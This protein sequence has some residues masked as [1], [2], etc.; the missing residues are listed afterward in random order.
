MTD[1]N[2]L[3]TAREAAETQKQL[4][5]DLELL[6]LRTKAGKKLH[7]RGHDMRRTFITLARTDGAID[8]LLRWVTHG[9]TSDMMDV[10]SSPPWSA[11]CTEVAKLKLALREGALVTLDVAPPATNRWLKTDGAETARSEARASSP[12]GWP[13]SGQR[14]RGKRR[15]DPQPAVDPALLVVT[16][17]RLELMFS[18]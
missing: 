16:P 1:A 11:L 14:T 4:I 5:A 2:P 8:G 10:Y 18:A 12:A 17:M 3:G 13:T 15:N 9:P 7:R 6:K